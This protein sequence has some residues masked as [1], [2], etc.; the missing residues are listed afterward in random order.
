M[1]AWVKILLLL[2]VLLSIGV[3]GVFVLVTGTTKSLQ[4]PA[5]SKT[6]AHRLLKFDEP[7]PDGWSYYG[8]IDYGWMKM[9][10]IRNATTK[11]SINISDIPNPG[12]VSADRLIAN[13]RIVRNEATRFIIEDEGEDT[14]GGEKMFWIRGKQER[15]KGRPSNVQ[16]GYIVVPNGRT[17]LVQIYQPR[18]GDQKYDPAL[19]KPFFDLI[20]GF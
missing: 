11:T 6:I 4:T 9:C 2:S 18:K 19:T 1:P 17:M 15:E 5:N 7:L 10:T 8:G 20:K 12:H 3:V 13:A 16:T 14:L